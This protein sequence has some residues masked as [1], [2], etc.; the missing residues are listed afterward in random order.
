[1]GGLGGVGKE[2]GNGARLPYF[3]VG[4]KGWIKK[5]KGEYLSYI[6]LYK[7]IVAIN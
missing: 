2:I 7:L 6:L 1:M 5:Q 3:E 4:S